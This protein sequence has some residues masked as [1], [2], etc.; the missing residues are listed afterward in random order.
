LA[1]A[2]DEAWTDLVGADFTSELRSQAKAVVG[3]IDIE[4]NDD[5]IRE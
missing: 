1:V 3:R 5:R 2:N 4:G